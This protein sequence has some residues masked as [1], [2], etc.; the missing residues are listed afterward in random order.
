MAGNI[1]G[2]TIELNGDTTKLDKAL[3]D[4]NKE[5]RT[6]QRQLSDVEKALKLNPGNVDLLKQKQ[7]LLGEE[8]KSTGDKLDMLKAAD[9]KTTEEMKS[10]TEGAAEKHN[11]LQ[12]QIAVTEAK[13]KS[14][15]KEFNKLS[16]LPGKLGEVAVGM[17]NV[18][19]KVSAAGGK[20]KSIG[21][22]FSGASV[23]AAGAVTG[24]TKFAMD[25]ETNMSKV[26]SILGLSGDDW[27]SYENRLKKGAK[28][29]G[30]SYDEYADAAYQAISASVP[31]DDVPKFLASS[32]KLA[33][34]GLT[35][36][37]TATDLLTT[38]MNSYG[39]SVKDCSKVNDILIQTQNRGKTTV[40]Q[41]GASMGKVIPVASSS[42]VSIKELAAQYSIL[43][44]QGVQTKI[45][46]TQ[47]RSML[48]ELSKNGS[49]A[50]TTLRKVSGK[51]F[52][53]LIKSGSNVGDVLKILDS[54]AKKN[55]K[56][57]KDMFG[58]TNAASAA[59][60]LMKNGTAGYDKELKAMTNSSG[61]ANRASKEMSD[62]AQSRLVKAMNQA[63]NAMADFGAQVL[64]IITP[65]I[66]KITDLAKKFDSLPE[67]VKKFT[68]YALLAVAAVSPLLMTIGTLT[69]G[70]GSM[71]T[72]IGK[73][74]NGVGRLAQSFQNLGGMAGIM[75]KAI[76]FLTSPLGIAIAAIS[77][78]IVVGVLLYKNWDKI[79]ATAKKVFTAIKNTV[80][81]VMNTI[82]SVI[83]ATWNGIKSVFS[84]VLSAIKTAVTLYFRAYL[85][86]IRAVM[87][88]IRTVVRTVWT[89]IKTVITTIVRGI[90]SA[91]SSVWHGIKS[92]T[93]SVFNGIRNITR[94]IWNG[95]RTAVMT[96]VHAIKSGVT[97]VW[98]AIRSTT[99]SVRNGIK[100]AMVRPIEAAKSVISG[101]ISRIK[102]MFHFSVS[103]PH[104]ALPHFSISPPGWKVGDLLKGK[105]PKLGISWY[106]E[107]AILKKPAIFGASGDSILAGGEAGPEA[108]API[109]TLKGYVRDAVAE[110]GAAGGTVFNITMTVNGAKDPET[111]AAEF[112]RSLKKRMRQGG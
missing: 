112:A 39:L 49:T 37:S 104:I 16:A 34:G 86:V 48:S 50:D 12:R 103:L 106:A 19:S 24:M 69:S 54:E 101:I 105:I 27:T 85:T 93:S 61:L 94:S 97:S 21:S 107:G 26:N 36:M 88:A 47:I 13:Q 62:T 89:A 82:K 30:K 44:R 43:T 68:V 58:N 63:K 8:I 108:V 83:T 100:S 84:T 38:I 66:Q 32:A 14:L 46:G 74:T 53:E 22:T 1:K 73:I 79:Q 96:P 65:M 45:A 9:K 80:V 18:G 87:I 59:L 95:I 35:D 64:P 3:R 99:S 25:T 40:D 109:D 75:G 90:Q 70:V 77:A 41:L 5:T 92:V 67:G 20:I 98:H 78:A 51:S 42:G 111:W 91:V 110:A 23:A 60:A 52:A 11:E 76:G 15:Q 6:V 31:K 28:E 102:S 29:L 56:S 7:R 10:G 33:K 4:V 71:I 72:G 55:G 57:L 81:P 17:Q 2:I